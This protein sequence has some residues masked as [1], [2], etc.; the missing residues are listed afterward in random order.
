MQA[1]FGCRLLL[2]GLVACA[3]CDFVFAQESHMLTSAHAHN[4]YLH[5]R[6]L[7]DALEHRFGSVEADVFLVRDDLWVAH[8]RS[9]LSETRTLRKL[10][11]EPLRQR[12]DENQ[13]SVYGDGQTLTLLI[14]VKTDAESTYRALHSQLV[15]FAGL[16]TKFHADKIEPGPVTIVLSGNRAVDLIA[17]QTPRFVGIDGRIGDLDRDQSAVLF[18]LVSDNWGLHFSWQGEGTCPAGE[19]QKLQELVQRVHARGQKFRL[20]ATPDK[21]PM[22]AVLR[23]A[24]VDMINTDELDGLAKFLSSPAN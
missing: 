7:L 23:E 17:A 16:L 14:D 22:W 6:P 15:E 18:P 12:I 10:Y 20:W 1:R 24:G 4:D 19:R 11:L 8:A 13:G 2:S 21:P 9:E 5:D 3:C